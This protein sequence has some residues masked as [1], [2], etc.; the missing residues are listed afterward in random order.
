MGVSLKHPQYLVFAAVAL[1]LAACNLKAESLPTAADVGLAEEIRMVEG[2]FDLWKEKNR[3]VFSA[4][5][6]L[7]KIV[8]SRKPDV[9]IHQLVDCVDDLRPS[10]ATLNGKALVVGVVCYQALTQTVAHEETGPD[11]DIVLKWP[12]HISP[13]ATPG[14]LAAAKKAWKKVLREGTYSFH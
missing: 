9:A 14:E 2:R 12:G 13:T 8:S 4:M 1:G 5:M 11:G 3:Y 7:E 6:K 10:N